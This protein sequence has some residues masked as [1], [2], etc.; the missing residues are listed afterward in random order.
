MRH[1]LNEEIDRITD[2]IGV[3]RDGN[4]KKNILDKLNNLKYWLYDTNGLGIQKIIEDKL[5]TL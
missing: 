4:S 5:S 3:K 2:L 1:S